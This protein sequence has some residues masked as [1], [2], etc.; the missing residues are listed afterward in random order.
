VTHRVPLRCADQRQLSNGL[1]QDRIDKC[2][3]SVRASAGGRDGSAVRSRSSIPS[4][5]IV[6]SCYRIRFVS[7]ASRQHRSR[8][9]LPAA[10]E[11][12]RIPFDQKW[13]A[14]KSE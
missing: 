4:L 8:F 12:L 3:L 13:S 2:V 10:E 7:T 11:R 6:G 14:T 9:Q 1:E 5:A